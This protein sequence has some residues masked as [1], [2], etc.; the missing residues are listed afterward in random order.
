MVIKRLF[1]K[2]P[3]ENGKT[4]L[5][6]MLFAVKISVK[7][8]ISSTLFFLHAFMPFIPMPDS[9]N[10]QAMSDYLLKKNEEVDN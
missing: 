8:S 2:H 1:C 7:L 9:Y 10:L 5:Q 6:H 3:N 4:W